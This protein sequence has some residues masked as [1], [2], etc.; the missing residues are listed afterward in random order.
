MS[1]QAAERLSELLEVTDIGTAF[2]TLGVK[3]DTLSRSLRRQGKT[4][5]REKLREWKLQDNE[6][7]DQAI[8]RQW[9]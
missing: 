1:A 7:L 4:E 5:L 9:Q 8:G 6:R 2:W 3:Y